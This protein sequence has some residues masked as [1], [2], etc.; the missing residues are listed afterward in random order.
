[1]R[2][3][4]ELTAANVAVGSIYLTLQNI[5]S[6]LIGV[7]GYAYLSRAV[8]QEE[9]G[10]IAGVTLLYSLVQTVVDLGINSSIAKFVSEDIGKGLDPSRHVVSALTLR[11]PLTIAAASSIAIFSQNISEALF[12]TAAYSNILCARTKG[13]P[14]I[15]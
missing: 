5:L 15:F 2:T 14:W 1:M 8:T 9:M 4:N 12:K 13:F 3:E 10:A 6:T 7:L 11:L